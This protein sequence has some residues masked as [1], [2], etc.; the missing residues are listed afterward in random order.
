MSEQGGIRLL[1]EQEGLYAF[2]VS[3]EGTDL[4]ALHTDEPAPLG[5]GTGPNPAALLLAGVANCLAASLLFALRKFKNTPGPLR[6]EITANKE[7]NAEGRW[8]LA[9]AQ[10][11]L[12][13]AD[14]ATDLVHF[15]RVLAQFEEFCIVTQ[16]VREGM[17]VDVQIVDAQGA[18]HIPGA[19]G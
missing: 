16:S 14:S 11:K 18:V 1:L 13:L 4:A 8:R 12:H 15:E 3:F 7:R 2:K 6:A 17:Q 9:R 10:V 5:E 19:K